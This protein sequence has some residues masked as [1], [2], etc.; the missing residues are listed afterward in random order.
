MQRS[1]SWTARTA[2]ATATTAVAA[3][4]EHRIEEYRQRDAYHHAEDPAQRRCNEQIGREENQNPFRKPL[5]SMDAHRLTRL[6][7][8][9]PAAAGFAA[10]PG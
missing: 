5:F 3:T 1:V 6:K 9:D 4:A 8:G 2:Q 7:T 10:S